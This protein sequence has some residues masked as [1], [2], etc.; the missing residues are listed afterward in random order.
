MDAK[1]G[2]ILFLFVAAC[3]GTNRP[4]ALAK[5]DQELRL[6]RF[7]LAYQELRKGLAQNPRSEALLSLEKPLRVRALISRAQDLLFQ[8]RPE[9]ALPLLA[10]AQTLDPSYR[11]TQVWLAKAREKLAKVKVAEGTDFLQRGKL[12][13]A[14]ASYQRALSVKGAD[15]EAL[16]GLRAVSEIFAKRR[17]KAKDH[18]RLALRA[19]EREDFDS[20]RYHAAIAL[21]QDPS[22]REAKLLI[23]RADIALAEG[24]RKHAEDLALEKRWAAAATA[25]VK[26][27]ELAEEA[28]LP[29]A[30][31]AR[32][33]ALAYADEA[34]GNQLLD[35]ASILIEKKQF[36]K[37]E[38][39][40]QQAKTFC[41]RDLLP[42]NEILVD[43]RVKRAS[44]LAREA[45]D[46]RR[47]GKLEE[48]LSV[49]E[50][51][52]KMEPEGLWKDKATQLRDR[53]QRARDL[54]QKALSLE[55]EGKL[56]KALP[57]LRECVALYPGFR[58]VAARYRRVLAALR[59]KS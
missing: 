48:M 58:D 16:Q 43:L 10:R 9:E 32:Q 15:P 14:L 3:A 5:T 55:K 54:Y 17:E 49:F 53:I 38:E 13:K 27:A 8:D 36:D 46:L 21:E 52:E 12:E 59:K 19:M 56:A 18:Y 57:L 51:L 41:K 37:A 4:A 11:P 20:A 7:D 50:T 40:V 24:A 45:E 47:E 6:G 29:W 26:A 31:K 23:E 39:L 22:L 2:L 44:E 25:M 35:E 30:S 33:E 42:L 1:A 34:K 28:G